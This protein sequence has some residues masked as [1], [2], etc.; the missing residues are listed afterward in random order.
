ML[1]TLFLD[2]LMRYTHIPSTN[3]NGEV[4]IAAAITGNIVPAILKR[5]GE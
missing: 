1:V 3:L 5:I 2:K 4:N